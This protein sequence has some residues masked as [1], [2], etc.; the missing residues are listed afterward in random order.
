MVKIRKSLF[1][2]CILILILSGCLSSP[3]ESV[4]I[5]TDSLKEVVIAETGTSPPGLLIYVAQSQ[6][7]FKEEGINV[8]ITAEYLHG[9]A[10]L[11]ALNRGD[12]VLATASETPLMRAGFAGHNMSTVAIIGTADK[13]LAVVGRKDHGIKIP[14]DISGKTVGV[15]IGSNGEYFL[16][17]FSLFAGIDTEEISKVDVKPIDMADRIKNGD[18]DA[19]VSWHPNWKNAEI[20]LGDNAA[21]FHG[22]GVYTTYFMLIGKNDYIAENPEIIKGMLR[23][24][25]KAEAYASENRDETI[26]ELAKLTG[27]DEKSASAV[28]DNYDL[29]IRLDQSLLISLDEVARWS[30]KKGLTNQTNIPNYLNYVHLASLINL[31]PKSVTVIHAE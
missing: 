22:E 14:S 28:I 11:N 4:G 23:A 9:S 3:P 21:T 1:W 27:L 19:V 10:N 12:V 5:K 15:T 7:F 6:G 29:T 2:I 26:I 16:D 13:H 30:I 31:S 17:L 25:L 20:A 24:L 18:V 8:T